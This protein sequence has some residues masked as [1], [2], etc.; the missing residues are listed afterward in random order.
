MVPTSPRVRRISGSRNFRSPPQKGFCNKIGEKQTYP[1]N[2]KGSPSRN[3][4][5]PFPTKSLGNRYDV[6]LRLARCRKASSTATKA[7]D[8]CRR[9]G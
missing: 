4:A 9:L 7:A 8:G 5:L 3:A 6:V 1:D 2:H